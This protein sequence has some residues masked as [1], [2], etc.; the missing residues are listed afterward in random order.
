M[1]SISQLGLAFFGLTLTSA[2]ENQLKLYKQIHQICFH[3]KGGYDWNTVYNLPIYL[4][5]FIFLEMKKFYDEEQEEVNKNQN[6][7]VQVVHPGSSNKPVKK[8][9]PPNFKPS[10]SPVKYS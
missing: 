5:N 9:T 7:D 8:V 3:G 6:P 2:K 10:R 4:R 1:E